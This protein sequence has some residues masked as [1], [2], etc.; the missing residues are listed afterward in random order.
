MD[1]SLT[2]P[3][4]EV[5]EDEWD[6]D[7]FVIPSLNV[8]DSDLGKP[9]VPGVTD[10]EPPPRAFKEAEKIYLGPHGAPPSSAKQQELNAA[11]RK[12]R[13]KQ[14]LKEADCKFSGTGRENKVETLRQRVG[15]KVSSATTPKSSPR[16]W[17]DP[18]CH[19]SQFERYRH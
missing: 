4:P 5:E 12:Q 10:R 9:D 19:E 17:P 6:T 1:P 16:D 14:K 15:S 7:G 2:Q 13:F 8:G 18:H 11:G 3:A